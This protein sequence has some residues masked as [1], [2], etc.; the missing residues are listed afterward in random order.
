MGGRLVI[1]NKM[2]GSLVI[3]IILGGRLVICRLLFPYHALRGLCRGIKCKSVSWLTQPP[4]L[5]RGLLP[6]TGTICMLRRNGL[7]K[8]EKNNNE[9]LNISA[10]L[11]QQP[12]SIQSYFRGSICSVWRRC[13]RSRSTFEGLSLLILVRCYSWMDANSLNY[14]Y[15][16]WLFE[17]LLHL[18]SG[19]LLPRHHHWQ[20][21]K[22][23]L[24]PCNIQSV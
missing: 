2:R 15:V 14:R 9:A 7:G 11:A 8:R 17:L 21:I 6:K 1:N 4:R 18:R 16:A 12:P 23:R 20:R 13:L 10:A 22:P 24:S 3:S 19:I 5:C